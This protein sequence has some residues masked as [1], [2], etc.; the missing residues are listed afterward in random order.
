M[1]QV[2]ANGISIECETFGDHRNPSILLIMGLATQMIAWPEAFCDMLVKRGFHVIRFDNRDVGLSQKFDGLPTPGRTAGLLRD[3]LGLKP[4]RIAY[5]LEDMADDAVG[6]LDALDI[7]SAHIVGASMGGMIAQIVAARHAP[8]VLSLTLIMSSSGERSMQKVR[9]RDFVPL[10]KLRAP[11]HSA[12]LPE[13]VDYLVKVFQM[14][15]SAGHLVDKGELRSLIERS[16]ERSVDTRGMARQSAAIAA[17][18]SRRVLLQSLD[19]P[20]LVLRGKRDILVPAMAGF[21]TAMQVRS[22]RIELVDDMGH[23]LPTPLLGHLSQS[24]A[25]H[26]ESSVQGKK[27]HA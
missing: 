24:I 10:L 3:L 18:G 14:I 9:L 12:P 26:C 25:D 15:G 21:D 8:R 23:D 20:T 19:V 6:V 1:A 27:T 5:R 4:R 2:F 13:H 16:V 7:D 17:N 11:S 22:A